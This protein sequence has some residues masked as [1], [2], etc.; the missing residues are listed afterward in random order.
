VSPHPALLLLFTLTSNGKVCQLWEKPIRETTRAQFKG[1]FA[2]KGSTCNFHF[3]A[4]FSH[5]VR[6]ATYKQSTS[7]RNAQVIQWVISP[8]LH[9]IFVVVYVNSTC[10]FY[11]SSLLLLAYWG[12]SC[13][14][15]LA[16]GDSNTHKG[17]SAESD[18]LL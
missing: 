4:G 16:P 11:K 14:H 12:N 2:Y 17:K 18:Y 9:L 3:Y 15:T 10:S 5:H 8:Y 6:H 13:Y 7:S 1:V